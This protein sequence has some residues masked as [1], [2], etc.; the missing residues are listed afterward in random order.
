MNNCDCQMMTRDELKALVHPD[1]AEER[2]QAV[3]FLVGL[4]TSTDQKERL[5]GYE[6]FREGLSEALYCSC[7]NYGSLAGGFTDPLLDIVTRAVEFWAASVDQTGDDASSGN[8][9]A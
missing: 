7:L 3:G 2:E 4:L 8:M 6:L 9:W 5:R 1:Q